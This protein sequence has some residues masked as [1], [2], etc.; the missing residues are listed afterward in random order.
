M[1]RQFI[2]MMRRFFFSDT[3]KR[4]EMFVAG[5][6]LFVDEVR[7]CLDLDWEC[8][9]AGL[10]AWRGLNMMSDEKESIDESICES[11]SYILDV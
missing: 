7:D 6:D 10:L 8:F 3:E 11:G 1:L 4:E 9:L 5:S 2:F